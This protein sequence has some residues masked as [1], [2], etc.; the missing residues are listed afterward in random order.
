MRPGS[1]IVADIKSVNRLK[2]S[3]VAPKI[4]TLVSVKSPAIPA[5]HEEIY[6]RSAFLPRIASHK[7]TAALKTVTKT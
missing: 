2:F 4:G 3:M 5:M 7:V 6:P 1:P